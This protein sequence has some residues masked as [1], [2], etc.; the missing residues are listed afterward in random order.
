MDV[1]EGSRFVYHLELWGDD[2]KWEIVDKIK[3]ELKGLLSS[4]VMIVYST[5]PEAIAYVP[6][7]SAVRGGQIVHD[8]DF[9]NRTE[10]ILIDDGGEIISNISPGYLLRLQ[11][12]PHRD[13]WPEEGVPVLKVAIRD[14][15][16]ANRQLH[17]RVLEIFQKNGINNP[18]NGSCMPCAPGTQVYALRRR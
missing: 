16:G 17:D 13:S 15:D 8:P 1:R 10:P 7:D 2:V 18:N 6:S 12:D 3:E 14:A 5:K 9:F 11:N 4:E